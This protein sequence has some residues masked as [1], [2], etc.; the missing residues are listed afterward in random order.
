MLFQPRWGQSAASVYSVTT[1]TGAYISRIHGQEHDSWKKAILAQEIAS[2][3]GVAPAIVHIDHP[4]L[5]LATICNFLSLPDEAALSMLEQ[6]EQSPIEGRQ[7]LLFAALRDLC[8]VVYGAVFLRPPADLGSVEFASREDTLML[9]ECFAML[10]TGK[11]ALGEP[12]H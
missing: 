4:Y 10:S 3:H 1:A 12:G 5:D 2:Q 8:R 11:L 9:G 6:Q 7:K